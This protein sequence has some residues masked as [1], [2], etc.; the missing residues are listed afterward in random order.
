M[1]SVVKRWMDEQ[2]D[3]GTVFISPAFLLA[4]VGGAITRQTGE[5]LLGKR[6]ISALEDLPGLRLVG[7]GDELMQTA[8]NP[9]ANLGLRGADSIYVSVAYQ[10]DLPLTSL[11]LDQA[12]RAGSQIKLIDIIR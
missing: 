11:D 4:E 10:L 8:A 7:S 5:P 6:A 3:D 1:H 2:R 9:A 12:Q